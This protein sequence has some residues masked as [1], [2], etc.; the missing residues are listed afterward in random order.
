MK[1][2]IIVGAVLGLM[3]C[4]AAPSD[5]ERPRP[6]LRI[7]G[8]RLAAGLAQELTAA[9]PDLDVRHVAASPLAAPGQ[10]QKGDAELGVTFADSVY[11]TQQAN[12]DQSSSVSPTLRAISA[13]HVA[14]ILLFV[15]SESG[16]RAVADIRGRVARTAPTPLENDPRFSGWPIPRSISGRGTGTVNGITALPQLVLLAY[17]ITPADVRNTTLDP[18]KAIAEIAEGRV[19]AVFTVA[20]EANTFASEAL[21]QGAHLMS[22]EGAAVER[23][24]REYSFIK[25]VNIPAGTYPGQTAA[26]HTVGVT[27]VL[28]C[29][30]DLAEQ[31]AYDLTRLYF[32]ALPTISAHGDV[33]GIDPQ[34]APLTPIPL[35]EGAARYFRETEL[36]R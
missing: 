33:Q 2:V 6:L 4:H 23:L 13:L 28:V 35:H 21:E 29:R 32:E 36:F 14:P 22:I 24:R 31:L 26:V 8:S 19:D 1:V 20:F 16:I 12:T 10:V 11:F 3:S 27:M 30:N 18:S 17:G 9:R 25:A 34:Q 15:R 7:A 5:E